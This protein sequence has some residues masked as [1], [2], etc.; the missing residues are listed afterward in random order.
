MPTLPAIEWTR[1]A[2]NIYFI[3][4]QCPVMPLVIEGQWLV[5][6]SL[7]TRCDQ[8]TLKYTP[9]N[10]N[11]CTT[12]KLTPRHSFDPVLAGRSLVILVTS[13]HSVWRFQLFYRHK[14]PPAAG[15]RTDLRLLTRC[16]KLKLSSTS[17]CPIK[18]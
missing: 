16:Q 4:L 5:S 17:R 11:L 10:L 1:K 7:A 14:R 8:L 18:I 15:S 13:Q 3:H 9:N 2:E 12:W 6:N